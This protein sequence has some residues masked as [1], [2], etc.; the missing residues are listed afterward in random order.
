MKIIVTLTL[1]LLTFSVL[2][3]RH[4]KKTIFTGSYPEGSYPEGSYPEG[5]YPEGSYP[6]G[7]YPEGSYPEG[8]Y[9][10]GSYPEGSYPEGS[11]PEGSYPEGSYPEGSYPEGSYPEGFAGCAIEPTVAIEC[12][13]G[14]Y[15]YIGS[16]SLNH[17]NQNLLKREKSTSNRS[18][19]KPKSRKGSRQ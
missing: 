2:A 13:E 15:K 16:A 5:S 12:P 17:I 3:K 18:G 9:P 7:S 6:E 4:S 8:S 19:Q 1:V 14:T 10:E 11:Y